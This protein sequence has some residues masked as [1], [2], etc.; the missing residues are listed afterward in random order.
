MV[1]YN[2]RGNGHP[3]CGF[4]LVRLQWWCQ[5][6]YHAVSRQSRSRYAGN[7]VIRF[8]FR[9]RPTTLGTYEW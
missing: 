4:R 6:D 2:D 7:I 1:N 8:G 3:S 9:H 5:A